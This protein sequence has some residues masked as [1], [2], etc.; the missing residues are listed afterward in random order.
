MSY[1]PLNRTL[2]SLLKRKFKHVKISKAGLS[3]VGREYFTDPVSGRRRMHCAEDGEAYCVNCP[4]CSDNRFR[5]FINHMW[6]VLDPEEGTNNLHL[7]HCFNEENCF[8]DH[9]R[10]L[11][12]FESLYDLPTDED[13]EHATITSGVVVDVTQLE[14]DWPG[15]VQRVCDLP[16]GHAARRYLWSRNFDPD[17]LGRYAG[18]CYCEASNYYLARNRLIFPIHENGKLKGW[19]AR[20]VGDIDWKAQGAPPKYWWSP[21]MPK[22]QLVYNLNRAKQYRTGVLGEGFMDAWAVGNAGMCCWG[23]HVS[24]QQQNLLIGAFRKHSLVLL[25]DPEAMRKERVQLLCSQLQ[26]AFDGGFAAVALPS[27]V[28]PGS[29]GRSSDFLRQYIVSEAAKQGVEVS[30]SKRE[31]EESRQTRVSA[32]RRIVAS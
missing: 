25:L 28:D 20:Y 14:I 18:V 13:L 17:Y 32:K 4:Y 7:C 15:K 6:G 1:K 3:Q 21:G 19:Q 23:E 31:P 9:S 16:V 2:Y 11:E 8:S 24:H 29:F 5:L 10:R 30:W 12:L 22:S 27:G 26:N